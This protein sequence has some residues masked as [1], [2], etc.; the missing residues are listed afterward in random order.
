MAH[1]TGSEASSAP[2]IPGSA[3][4][5]FADALETHEQEA[6][7]IDPEE[8][9]E[10]ELSEGD[11]PEDEEAQHEEDEPEEEAPAIDPPVSWGADAKELFNQLPPELQTQV[12]EREA[13]REKAVQRA[14]T[15]AAEAKRSAST[16]AANTVAT[17]QRQYADELAQYA[18]ILKP[19]RPNPALAA[20]DP[21]QYLQELA[22]FQ[23][24][25]AQYQAMVQQAQQ[26]RGQADDLSRQALNEALEA[27][28]RRLSMELPEWNDPAQR[29]AL[30]TELEKVGAELGYTPDL[31]KQAGAADILALKKANEWR[32]KALKLDSLQKSKMEKVRAAKTLP[33]VV[34]PGVAPTRGELSQQRSQAAWQRV[35]TAKSK[36]AQSDAFADWLESSGH[37]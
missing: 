5:D 16:E 19:Q 32:M 12:A 35:K 9:E 30:L 17:I 25:D 24:A 11:E 33:K 6:G 7:E 10:E 29:V 31:M 36:A 15:E 21:N 37:I 26:A 3:V 34:K 27:D 28:A 1:P 23:A 20:E 18:E 13:Q 8:E 22:Y 2:A 14:T 4:E